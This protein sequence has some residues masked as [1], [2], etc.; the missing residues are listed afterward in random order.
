MEEVCG[1]LSQREPL[2]QQYRADPLTSL[3]TIPEDSSV[4]LTE[5]VLLTDGCGQ[6]AEEFDD[7]AKTVFDLLRC[8]AA[9]GIRIV[10]TTTH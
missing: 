2:L 3:R 10:A 7:L 6:L 8:G 5:A 4:N 1:L 9:H